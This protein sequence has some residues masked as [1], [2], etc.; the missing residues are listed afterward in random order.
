MTKIQDKN[1]NVLRTKRA[2]KMNYR[3]FLIILKRA[4][5][6]VNNRFFLDVENPDLIN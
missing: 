6:E 3:V 2:F 5:I 1:F 4:F